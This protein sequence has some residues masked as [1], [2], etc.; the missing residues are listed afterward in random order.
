MLALLYP[1][2]GVLHTALLAR[3]ELVTTAEVR[4][5]IAVPIREYDRKTQA[6]SVV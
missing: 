4:D 6:W 5:A 1:T 2:A 3:T